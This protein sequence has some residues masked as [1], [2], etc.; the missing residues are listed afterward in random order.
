[1]V[2]STAALNTVLVK[3]IMWYF[4]FS[5]P[6]WNIHTIVTYIS[7]F[8]TSGF[9]VVKKNNTV[10]VKIIC[11]LGSS[12]SEEYTACVFRRLSEDGSSVIIQNSI[13][14]GWFGLYVEVQNLVL[15]GLKWYHEMEEGWGY[16]GLVVLEVWYSKPYSIEIKLCFSL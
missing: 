16:Y 10:L 6:A 7:K 5:F 3:K 1:M 11:C 9:P 8:F 14:T 13:H 12:V 2:Q 4:S 15:F